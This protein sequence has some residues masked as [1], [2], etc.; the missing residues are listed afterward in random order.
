MV[1]ESL[2]TVNTLGKSSEK[3][4]LFKFNALGLMSNNFLIF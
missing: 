2:Q 3:L 4:F 1:P